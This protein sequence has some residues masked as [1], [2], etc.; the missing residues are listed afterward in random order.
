MAMVDAKY[1]FIWGTCG[2]PGNSYDSII[3]QSTSLWSSIQ[4]G[5]FLP[6][7]TQ[8]LDVLNVPPIILGDS[9]FPF[10][11]FLMKPY[12]NAVLSEE[13][14]YFDYRLSRARM[15]VEGAYGQLKGRWRLLLNMSEGNLY[16]TKMTT[17][18]CMVLH[19]LC[20][21]SNDPIPSALD[22]TIDPSTKKKRDRDVIRDLL[23]M[24]VSKKIIDPK[25]N[26]ANKDR[27]AITRK[28]HNEL[29]KT[30]K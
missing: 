1:R 19:N 13:Q 4:D 12:T 25:K 28:L 29:Q 10:E 30:K 21:E 27:N 7:F 18:A 11:T 2:F 23:L 3:L 14:R 8:N 6:N 22:I 17:L 24:K 16:Q 20:I 26:E 9:A 5:K 15:L